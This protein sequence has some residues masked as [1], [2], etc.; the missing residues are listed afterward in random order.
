MVNRAQIVENHADVL[1][2]RLAYDAYKRAIDQGEEED[3]EEEKQSH[4][5]ADQRFFIAY[6]KAW[7]GDKKNFEGSLHGLHA[8]MRARVVGALRQFPP[9]ARAFRCPTGSAM[10]PL[11]RCSV[12]GYRI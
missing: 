12:L 9:F 11:R 5:T 2:I 7:C 10:N 1:G 8:P 6:G 3:D 4:F